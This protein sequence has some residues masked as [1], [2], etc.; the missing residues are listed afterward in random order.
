VRRAVAGDRIFRHPLVATM[1]LSQETLDVARADG[2]RV[3]VYLAPAGTPDHDAMILLDRADG[4]AMAVDE[5]STA[6]ERGR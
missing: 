4:L 1:T 3:I 6:I 5:S 2:Q